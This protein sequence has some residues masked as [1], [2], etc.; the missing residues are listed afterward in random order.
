M[1]ERLYYIAST[2]KARDTQPATE[3]DWEW[4]YAAH[5]DLVEPH[6]GPVTFYP[7]KND[8]YCGRVCGVAEYARRPVIFA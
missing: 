6:D 5:R 2:A 8:P 4:A 3:A 7:L 1:T